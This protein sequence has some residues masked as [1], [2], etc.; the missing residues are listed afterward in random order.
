MIS[1]LKMIIFPF[2]PAIHC[3]VSD[4]A[5][6]SHGSI[7]VYWPLAISCFETGRTRVFRFQSTPSSILFM[8]LGTL[9]MVGGFFET[10]SCKHKKM[11]II[12]MCDD[13]YGGCT[14]CL[15]R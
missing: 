4:L 14:S 5:R 10:V 3:L 9:V 15:E 12:V 8:L 2:K 6:Q 11:E 1:C 13:K 7:I